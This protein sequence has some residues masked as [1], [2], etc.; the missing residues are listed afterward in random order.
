[1]NLSW[2]KRLQRHTLTNGRRTILTTALWLLALMTIVA[3]PHYKIIDYAKLNDAVTM[4]H[5]I[6]RDNYGMMWFAT[7]DGLYRYDGYT[8]VNFKSHSGD[9]VNM[10]SNQQWRWH[11]VSDSRTSV[12][13][14]HTYMPVHRRTLRLRAKTG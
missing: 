4:V 2:R 7:D 10:P 8:F 9:G 14:R 1:M 3:Q 12:P 5:R 13:V 6:V 11:L